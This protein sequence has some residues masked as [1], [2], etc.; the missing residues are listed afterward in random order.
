M[1]MNY[2]G[3]DPRI[4]PT[5][6]EGVLFAA[7]PA[8]ERSRKTRRFGARK[9]T[10]AVTEP[11]SL[12]PSATMTNSTLAADE[13][14][15]AA[16]PALATRTTRVKKAGPSP[17][18]IAMALGA[19]VV[20]G[21]VGFYALQPHGGVTALSPGQPTTSEVAVAPITPDVDVATN[22]LPQPATAAAP[23]IARPSVAAPSV[24]A[25]S[26]RIRS[27]RAAAP[28][29]EGNAANVSATLPD[30]PQPYSTVNPAAP[31]PIEAAPPVQEV[32]PAPAPSEP[33]PETVTPPTT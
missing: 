7:T 15:F 4:S 10:Q 20:L 24:A 29:A 5:E 23:R 30:G 13:T 9:A 26:A 6:A 22:T 27:A 11:R 21:G 2:T 18:V 32:A 1:S 28:S 14:P 17:T 3:K 12:P 25:P 31:A 8:W 16:A 19:V 33:A